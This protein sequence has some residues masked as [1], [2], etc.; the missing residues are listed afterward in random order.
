MDSV[1]FQM[2]TTGIC[3][4]PYQEKLLQKVACST[5]INTSIV[6]FS[7]L[8]SYPL[9]W[10]RYTLINYAIVILVT[11]WVHISFS[12]NIVLWLTEYFMFCVSITG[13]A[14]LCMHPSKNPCR[15]LSVLIPKSQ[16]KQ[17]KKVSVNPQSWTSWF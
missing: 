15:Y 4:I 16:S 11:N 10:S 13:C 1:H 7:V 8:C 5:P 12:C 6:C 14:D 3:M 9:N 2:K 17:R